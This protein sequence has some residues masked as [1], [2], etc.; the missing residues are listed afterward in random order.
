MTSSTHTQ[1]GWTDRLGALSGA[2]YVVLVVVGNSLAA[3]GEDSNPTGAQVIEQTKRTADST[4]ASIGL[5]LEL[6]SFVAFAF[7]V[8]W[9][10][11]HLRRSG[12]GWLAGVAAVG[13]VT[14]LAI[15][16]GSAAPMITL[17][18]ERKTIDPELA[19][20]LN[21]LN[22]ASFVIT[23]VSFGVLLL[24]AGLAGLASGGLGPISSWIAVVLGA[25]GI[26]LPIATKL[27][28][29]NTNPIPFLLGLLW[30]L[31]VSIRLGVSRRA[32]ERVQELV[33]A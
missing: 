27:D 12:A 11:G 8:A 10:H 1:V 24:G 5:S 14:T 17:F 15:K 13:G 23:F 28:P 7:F 4:S 33:A 26:V 18:A 20:I 3:G 21:L 6:L 2:A 16:L 22:G 9:L 29:W 32:P 31:V 19:K 25:A 30:V